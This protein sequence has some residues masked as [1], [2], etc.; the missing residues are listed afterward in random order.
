MKRDWELIR[1]ILAKVEELPDTWS[2][3]LAG[4]IAG[5]LGMKEEDVDYHL[6]L[7]IGSGLVVGDLQF[8]SQPVCCAAALTWDGHEFL[9]FVR[10]DTAW[11]RIKKWLNEKGFELSFEA[12]V[13]AG[14]SIIATWDI[15]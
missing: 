14:K 6:W 1:T 5:T 11:N 10:S 2:K 8:G 9:A 15:G 12:I 3:L 4:D 7:L 13:A